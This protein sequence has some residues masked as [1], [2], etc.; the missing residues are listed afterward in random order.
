M[1]LFRKSRLAT[2]AVACALG[3]GCGLAL[4]PSEG[5][6]D[7]IDIYSGLSAGNS[8][9]PNIIFLV[10]NSPN[11]S[12]AAQH[13]PDNGG[14]QGAAELAAIHDELDLINSLM[15]ANVGRLGRERWNPRL[16]RRLHS[17]RSP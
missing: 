5:L 8:D 16:G 10:D 15:P 3:V 14:I 6:A 17:L 9:M 12:R 2:F 1:S 4:A 13:W 11:W 7:D